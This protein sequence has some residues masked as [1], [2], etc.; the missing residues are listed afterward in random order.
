[1]PILTSISASG[2][3]HQKY[4]K[5]KTGDTGPGGGKI[6]DIG[7]WTGTTQ[8][9]EVAPSTWNGAQD[10]VNLAL[11]AQTTTYVGTT[12]IGSSLG[13]GYANT[14]AL[15][16]NNSTAGYAI[17]TCRAYTGGGKTDW[18]LPSY[19]ELVL[20]YNNRT[21]T[22]IGPFVSSYYHSSSEWGPGAFGAYNAVYQMGT[23]VQAQSNKS[24][25]AGVR[26]IRYA[27]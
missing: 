9:L 14:L 25:P 10:P 12:A 22:G 15:V 1:M 8:Y 5:Y 20:L 23:A 17:T 2:V 7:F 18:F 11:S 24:S 27:S 4:S 21:V 16:A 19:D 26:P 13:T 3:S 6:I